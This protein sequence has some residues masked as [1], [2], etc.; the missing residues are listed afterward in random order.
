MKS[1]EMK[2]LNLELALK[3]GLINWFQY[4]E[5]TRKACRPEKQTGV[6]NE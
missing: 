4:L 5:L 2:L 6:D 3:C 1:Q